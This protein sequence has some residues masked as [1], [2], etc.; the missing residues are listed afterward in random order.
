MYPINGIA[1]KVLLEKWAQVCEFKSLSEYRNAGERGVAFERQICR[2]LIASNEITFSFMD[3]A[4]KKHLVTWNVS[5]VQLVSGFA[6]EKGEHLNVKGFERYQTYI[7]SDVT[8]LWVPGVTEFPYIDFI[9]DAK[10][11]SNEE[12]TLY[13]LQTSIKKTMHE[14]PME[15]FKKSDD[16]LADKA[17]EGQANEQK[18]NKI[19]EEL[20]SRVSFRNLRRAFKLEEHEKL[21]YVLLDG[22]NSAKKKARVEL[23]L[24]ANCE[25]WHVDAYQDE[26]PF[27]LLK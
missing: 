11:S 2:A 10:A 9:L 15:F 14:G 24:D 23:N 20:E 13:V 19:K 16:L 25:F 1:A 22:S 8:T 5:H 27:K 26:N 3:S 21:V 6:R 4:Q 12:R 7:D 17:L 18:M